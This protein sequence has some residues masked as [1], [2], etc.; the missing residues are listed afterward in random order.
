MHTIIGV[1]ELRENLD[2]YAQ[3]VQR[4][5]SF[6]VT[7]KSRPLFSIVPVEAEEKW[8]TVVDFT[9]IMKGGVSLERVLKAL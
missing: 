8:E 1:K 5:H 6:V 7:R 4:G 3:K 9:D 2:T